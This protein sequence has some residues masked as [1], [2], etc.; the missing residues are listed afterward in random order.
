LARRARELARAADR[1][2]AFVREDPTTPRKTAERVGASAFMRKRAEEGD[3]GAR[4]GSVRVGSRGGFAGFAV[5]GDGKTPYASPNATRIRTSP[6]LAS[7]RDLAPTLWRVASQA[8]D[9]RRETEDERRETEDE[10]P[11]TSGSDSGAAPL[12]LAAEAL[13]VAR[14]RR[15]R[16]RAEAMEAAAAAAI[17][18]S[19]SESEAEEAEPDPRGAFGSPE[20]A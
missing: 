3:E 20:A 2:V 1:A 12:S 18:A 7:L 11:E 10:R 4:A 17:M 16:T 15:T 13:S 14:R 9:E 8:E 6:E 5:G 19:S